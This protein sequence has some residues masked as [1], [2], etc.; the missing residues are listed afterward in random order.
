MSVCH[1][2][3]CRTPHCHTTCPD[4]LRERERGDREIR[5]RGVIREATE[6]IYQGIENVIKRRNIK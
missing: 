5:R 1:H 6:I 2:C 3:Q 4:Y